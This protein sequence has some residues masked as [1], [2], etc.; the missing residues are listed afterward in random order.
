MASNPLG[1]SNVVEIINTSLGGNKEDPTSRKPLKTATEAV[2]ILCHA[3][4]LALDFK[5]LG[6]DEDDRIGKPSCLK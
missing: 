2:A 3:C 5:L 1:R 4:M 6:F